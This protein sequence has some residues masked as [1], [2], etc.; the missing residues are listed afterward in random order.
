MKRFCIMLAAA[1][2]AG[3]LAACGAAPQSAAPAESTSLPAAVTGQPLRRLES[4]DA[5]AY[6][7]VQDAGDGTHT[8]LYRIDLVTGACAPVCDVS[9]CSHTAESCPALHP[10]EAGWTVQV[11]DES[12]LLWIGNDTLY[13]SDRDGR[14]LRYVCSNPTLAFLSNPLY[15]DGEAVYLLNFQPDT[16]GRNT[17]YR[18][19]L[20][21]PDTVEPLSTL[22][23][24]GVMLGASA[25]WLVFNLYNSAEQTDSSIAYNID[26]GETHSLLD[27]PH[28]EEPTP[29]NPGHQS[30]VADGIYYVFDFST[31]TVTGKDPATGEMVLQ[32]SPFPADPNEGRGAEYCWPVRVL[33]GWLELDYYSNDWES[34]NFSITSFS[35]LVSLE[36]GEV[37]RKPDL[38]MQTWNGYPHSPTVVLDLGDRLLV[39]SRTEPH[40][41]THFDNAGAPYTVE[42]SHRILATIPVEDYLSGTPNYT[43]TEGWI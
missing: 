22:P 37:R 31:R 43:E 19:D 23:G 39:T 2:L 11:L 3:L 27:V 4:G 17:L 30:N 15:T 35:Y 32:S 1:M 20:N 28:Q 25:R 42:S 18:L 24:S 21:T 33:N 26:T 16:Q 29:H 8:I 7:Q 38:P 10:V 9:G 36:T 34:S 5:D 41:E 40:I 6:Y 14:N 12:T 13:R